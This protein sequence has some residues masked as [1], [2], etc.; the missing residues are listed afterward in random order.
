M[1]EPGSDERSSQRGFSLTELLIVVAIIFILVATAVA[2]IAP[3]MQ[4]RRL[5]A[6]A[7]MIAGKL[8]E[9]RINAIKRNT[10]TNLTFDVTN[11]TVQVQTAAGVNI[12]V[13]EKLPADIGLSVAPV[14]VGAPRI[15]FD[16]LGRLQTAAPPT[17]TLQASQAGKRKTV[18][19]SAVGKIA[20]GAM[21][22][23]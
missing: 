4:T 23:Y 2:M 19:V 3:T 10:Q 14:A 5:D 12:G 7:A 18:Q 22:S 9:A 13:A 21:T 16:S 17:V 1:S 8:T 20:V 11:R 15:T 6:A